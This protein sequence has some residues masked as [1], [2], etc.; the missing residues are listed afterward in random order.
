MNRTLLCCAAALLSVVVGTRSTVAQAPKPRRI[1]RAIELLAQGQPIYYTGS[2]AGTAGSYEQGMK[3]AQTYA[4]Y[5]SYD[6]EHAPYDIKG[7]A[8]YMRGLVAG[9]RARNGHRPRAGSGKGP[10]RG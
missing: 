5:L 9:G 7:L 3:D 10:A 6:M 1:N 4:D 2:H 8:D